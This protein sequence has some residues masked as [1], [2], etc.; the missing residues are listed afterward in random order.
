VRKAEIYF[1]A[2]IH[3]VAWSII[4]IMKQKQSFTDLQ[5]YNTLA[6]ETVHIKVMNHVKKHTSVRGNVSGAAVTICIL[7]Q[8]WLNT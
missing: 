6:N 3:E 7:K 2:R 4:K 1:K 5:F 8:C